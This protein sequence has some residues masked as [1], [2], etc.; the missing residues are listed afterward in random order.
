MPT[1]Q[2]EALEGQETSREKPRVERTACWTG[3]AKAE[4]KG[5]SEEGLNLRED[6]PFI[7]LDGDRREPEYLMGGRK[8]HRRGIEEPNSRYGSRRNTLRGTTTS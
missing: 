2:S 6:E 8:E 5:V 7:Q 4:S 3:D 1:H